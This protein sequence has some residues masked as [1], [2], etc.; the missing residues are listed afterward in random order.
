MKDSTQATNSM[1]KQFL[2]L[3]FFFLISFYSNAQESENSSSTSLSILF[4]ADNAFGF[5]PTI[6]GSIPINDQLS[7]SFYSILWTNPTYGNLNMAG[8]D[9]WLETGGGLTWSLLDG[10]LILNPSIGLTHG[11]LQSGAE[12]SLIG[13][14]LVP[15]LVTIYNGQQGIELESLLTYYKSIRKDQPTDITTD[16]SILNLYLGYAFNKY[17]ALGGFYDAFLQTRQT[18]GQFLA[19]YQVLG[20]YLRIKINDFANFRFSAGYNFMPE[21]NGFSSE[22]YRLS[23]LFPLV[24]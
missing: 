14:G 3:T 21:A 1:K 6:L 10:Q 4:N 20:G 8:T 9:M 5:Y 7:A 2:L 18:N 11:R 16:F 19:L 24:P 13:E 22:Y 23:V 17:L 15:S 12:R